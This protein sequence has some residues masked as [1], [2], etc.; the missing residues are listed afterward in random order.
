MDKRSE[1]DLLE[2]GDGVILDDQIQVRM[3]PT[4]A[5]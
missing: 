2:D 5:G 3:S 1:A 4:E